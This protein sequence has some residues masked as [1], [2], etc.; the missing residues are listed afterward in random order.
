MI[1]HFWTFKSKIFGIKEQL[2]MMVC[3]NLRRTAIPLRMTFS[4]SLR[5]ILLWGFFTWTEL[6]APSNRRKRIMNSANESNGLRVRRKRNVIPYLPHLS[7]PCV[8]KTPHILQRRLE[9]QKMSH[10]QMENLS[11]LICCLF[12]N[13]KSQTLNWRSV[14]E[15]I[16][17]QIGNRKMRRVWSWE[18]DWVKIHVLRL[19]NSYY[20]S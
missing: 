12:W 13:R 10:W 16:C 17:W 18:R 7:N 4:L 9:H 15:R 14:R 5:F 20:L 11:H 2:E 8:V 19:Y 6:S 1:R 3:Q